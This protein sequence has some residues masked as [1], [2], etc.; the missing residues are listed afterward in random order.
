M[1]YEYRMDSG[2]QIAGPERGTDNVL[3]VQ[4]KYQP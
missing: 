1:G 3:P 4:L 2:A